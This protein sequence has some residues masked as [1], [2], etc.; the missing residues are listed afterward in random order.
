MYG[1]PVIGSNIGGIPELIDVG[2]TG[3]L[4]EANNERDLEEKI[5]DLWNDEKKLQRY[6]MNCKSRRIESLES[7]VE[8]LIHLYK[9]KIVTMKVIEVGTGYTSIPANKGAATEKI[10]EE[11]SRVFKKQN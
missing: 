8:K 4:F 5:L 3:E 7:Y 2:Q 10:I 6:T 11:L 9:E 1:T